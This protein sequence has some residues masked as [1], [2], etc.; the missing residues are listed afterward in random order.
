MFVC[1]AVFVCM[2]SLFSFLCM[3]AF[4]RGGTFVFAYSSLFAQPSTEVWQPAWC[5]WCYE[6]IFSPIMCMYISCVDLCVHVFMNP[7]LS[8]F[9]CVFLGRFNILCYA[10][11]FYML[12]FLRQMFMMHACVCVCVCV[13]CSLALFSAIERYR[14][15]IIIII[16]III[17][18]MCGSY[19]SV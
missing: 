18:I 9:V 5:I 19:P 4:W 8:W 12:L 13:C 16:I 14:S 15:K 1:S 17:I 10:S 3:Q 6:M 2:H 7:M 11:G